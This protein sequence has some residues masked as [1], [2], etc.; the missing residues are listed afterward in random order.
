MPKL[1]QPR[2]TLLDCARSETR[3]LSNKL[4]FDFVDRLED[5][6]PQIAAS[7]EKKNRPAAGGVNAFC[8]ASWNAWKSRSRNN[9]EFR[10][11]VSSRNGGRS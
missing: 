7:Q 11:S 3:S 10:P 9:C 1:M 4:K 2:L 5:G 6:S 8:M